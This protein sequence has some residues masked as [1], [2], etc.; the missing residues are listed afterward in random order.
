MF[1]PRPV[2]GQ[3]VKTAL[4]EHPL[5]EVLEIVAVHP[6]AR[7]DG[8]AFAA[9]IQCLNG[10]RQ[11][12]RVQVRDFHAAAACGD[13][14]RADLLIRRVKNHAIKLGIQQHVKD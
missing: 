8:N 1:L 7:D 5:A 3:R 2:H 4:V 12:R 9:L 10:R 14:G 13:H 6:R 11:K